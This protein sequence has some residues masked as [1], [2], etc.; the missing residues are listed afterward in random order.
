[1]NLVLGIIVGALVGWVAF[2][3][4]RLNTGQGLGI[5]LAIGVFGGGMGVQFAPILSA[6]PVPQGQVNLFGLVIA[7]AAAGALL[8]IA[9]MLS[10][11]GGG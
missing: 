11:R 7:A 3:L 6:V 5:S 2:R 1:M 9:N 10:N 8:L 4:L